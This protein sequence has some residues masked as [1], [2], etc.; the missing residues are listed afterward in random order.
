MK[1][2][3]LITVL[4]LTGCGVQETKRVEGTAEVKATFTDVGVQS[5]FN[6]FNENKIN[7]E[8]FEKCLELVT[9]REVSIDADMRDAAEASN[10]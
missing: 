10:K 3:L 2:R 7:Y 4:I 9:S 5:C 8:Q 1:S 6:L